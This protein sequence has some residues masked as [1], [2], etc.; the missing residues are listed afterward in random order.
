MLLF[1]VLYYLAYSNTLDSF[2]F[3]VKLKSFEIILWVVPVVHLFLYLRA[4]L[5]FTQIHRIE[6][7]LLDHFGQRDT[8][9]QPYVAKPAQVLRLIRTPGYFFQELDLQSEQKWYRNNPARRVYLYFLIAL[10]LLGPFFLSPGMLVANC[11]LYPRPTVSL[12]LTIG[13]QALALI[14]A[15]RSLALLADVFKIIRG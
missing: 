13:L 8:Q 5:I 7:E 1:A 12:Y 11:F 6:T 3:F 10:F 9:G 14:L 4:M 15:V 2:L